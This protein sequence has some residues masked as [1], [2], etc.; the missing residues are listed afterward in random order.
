MPPACGK[1]LKTYLV[2]QG[3]PPHV[4]IQLCA[5]LCS[6]RH[7]GLRGLC[8][9]VTLLTE[10]LRAM[11][12]LSTTVA[13]FDTCRV[14]KASIQPLSIPTVQ[15]ARKVLTWRSHHHLAASDHAQLLRSNPNL[16]GSRFYIY[17][18]R[19]LKFARLFKAAL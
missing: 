13:G 9:D 8:A 15:L 7:Q 11:E 10:R 17:L 14:L 2:Q 18:Y 19:A 5:T 16:Y 4:C 3:L 12:K 1:L 6:R